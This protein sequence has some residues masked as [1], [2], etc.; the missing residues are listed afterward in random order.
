MP[1][2]DIA[3][4]IAAAT[5]HADSRCPR[6]ATHPDTASVAAEARAW[7][8]GGGLHPAEPGGP[9]DLVNPVL[10]VA[11]AMRDAPTHALRITGFF[12]TWLAAFAEHGTRTGWDPAYGASL[13]GILGGARTTPDAL[14]F[15]LA[16]LADR[17]TAAGGAALL[18]ELAGALTRH[19]A[20]A[21]REHDWVTR[22]VT[23][24]LTE[25]LDNRVDRTAVPML[26]VPQRLDPALGRPDAPTAP[27]VPQLAELA[28]LL[29]GVDED[30][31]GF[32]AAVA[33]GARMTL[34]PVLMREYGHSVPAAFQ[35]ATVLFGAWK[36]QLDHGVGVFERE[37]DGPEAAAAVRQAR[38]LVDWVAALHHHHADLHVRHRAVAVG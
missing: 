26:I 15:T 36:T 18:P 29:T 37:P 21:R 2:G 31:I 4:L 3:S 28:G 11:E 10:P 7:A 32:R 19:T 9:V 20:A 6:A 17:I 30:L 1:R 22:D 24:T 38:A 35:S 27:G 12:A 8:R 34:V 5:A 14:H 16:D 33:T 23:P 25:F 13:A